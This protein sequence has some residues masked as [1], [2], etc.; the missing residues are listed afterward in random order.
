MDL[1]DL[2]LLLFLLRVAENRVEMR[3]CE[4]NYLR[5]VMEKGLQATN[6]KKKEMIA[7]KQT[8][9]KMRH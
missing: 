9:M 7:R 2:L 1:L 4:M 8:T 5:G 3:C 6:V